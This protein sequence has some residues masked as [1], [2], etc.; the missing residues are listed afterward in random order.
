MEGNQLMS[1]QNRVLFA[2]ALF[3]LFAIGIF[4]AVYFWPGMR[5]STAKDQS[6]PVTEEQKEDIRAQ[7][8]ATMDANSGQYGA[9]TDLTAQ[10]REEIRSQLV[11]EQPTSGSASQVS[12]SDVP[13]EEKEDI[14]AQLRSQMQ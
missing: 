12:D 5:D 2:A 11:G 4:L 8:R 10:E 14:R 13:D 9:T 6:V 7:L 1:P 3:A